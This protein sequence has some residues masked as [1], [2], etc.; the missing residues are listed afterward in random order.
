MCARYD[1][2]TSPERFKQVFGT[3]L[4]ERPDISSKPSAEVFPGG[5]APIIRATPE[6]LARG[7]I[8]SQNPEI[9]DHEAVWAMF[10]LIPHWA[11]DTK[12][13]RSTYNAGN[14]AVR[15]RLHI[16]DDEKKMVLPLFRGSWK[17]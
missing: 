13:F 9:P 5:W 14:H 6:G 12:I 4:P 7:V 10:G 3:A 17:T 16:T 1:P 11:K 8:H 15:S 2:V